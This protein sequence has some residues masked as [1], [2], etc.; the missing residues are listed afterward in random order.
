MFGLG[1]QELIIILVLVLIIFGA[2]KLPQVG[3][4]LGKGLR[5]FK[6]GMK[7]DE[8]EKNNETGRLEDGSEDKKG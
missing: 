1:T 6:S 4:A 8:D 3:S 7:D 5:N 2:G